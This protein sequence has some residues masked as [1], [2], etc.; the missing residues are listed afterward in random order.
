M[1]SALTIIRITRKIFVNTNAWASPPGNS[2][3]IGQGGA[4]ALGEPDKQ[5]RLR[6]SALSCASSFKAQSKHAGDLLKCRF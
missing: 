1:P 4:W 6:T 2:G 5:P 3:L